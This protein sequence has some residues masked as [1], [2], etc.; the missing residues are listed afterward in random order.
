MNARRDSGQGR[1]PGDEKY[2]TCAIALARRGIGRVSPNPPVGC[3]IVRDEKV[4][5]KGYHG[6]F[7]GP[8][9][10]IQA[11][12]CAGK[13]TRGATAY[14]TLEPCA[15]SFADK[16]T[17]PC[18]EALLSAGVIRVVIAARDPNPRVNGEGIAQLQAAGIEVTEGILA[19]EGA[20]LIRGFRKWIRTGRPFIILKVARTRDDFVVACLESGNWFT[21]SE[22]RRWVHRLRAEVDGVLVG[23]KAAEK[24]N[25]RLTVREVTGTNPRRVVLDSHLRLPTNLHL[26]QDGAAPTLVFT[27]VGESKVT[28]W[29]EQI[30][31]S[32]SPA[33]V[34]LSEVLDA[35]GE[36]GI[37]TLL[38]EGGPTV[39]REFIRAGLVDEVVLFTAPRCADEEVQKRPGLR[40]A[41]VIPKNWRPVTQND[42]EGDTMIVAEPVNPS[43]EASIHTDI[44]ESNT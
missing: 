25:P 3:V 31:V 24:D 18:T 16:K 39:H 37:T 27:T 32:P 41:V 14:I 35:L 12:G 2:M 17:P 19:H 8:H 42:L 9:A 22:S 15:V 28:P 26:F 11:L 40:N 1:L 38:V 34:N 10:E 5:G 23:R 4:V 33:G 21:S 29:G 6:Q 13:K 30:K 44:P 20:R 43:Y 7:G 36:R